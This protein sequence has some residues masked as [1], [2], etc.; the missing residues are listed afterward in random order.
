[1]WRTKLRYLFSHHQISGYPL[2]F[3]T[4]WA[5]VMV[6]LLADPML[7]S[8]VPTTHF[9]EPT[10]A[11]VPLGAQPKQQHLLL[12]YWLPMVT[13]WPQVFR[14]GTFHNILPSLYKPSAKLRPQITDWI[15]LRCQWQNLGHLRT[16]GCVHSA[17][18][19]SNIWCP[20]NQ[21]H[22]TALLWDL[23]H[24]GQCPPDPISLGSALSTSTQDLSLLQPDDFHVMLVGEEK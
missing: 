5:A 1:M 14:L 4:S 19:G 9:K 24:M 7:C 17:A 13:R 10:R 6:S 21:P 11:P 20:Q 15:L 18:L 8:L 23:L 3:P 12:E 2:P 22:A 16:C